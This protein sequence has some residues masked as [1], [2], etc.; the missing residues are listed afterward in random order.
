MTDRNQ[1]ERLLKDAYAARRRG[2]VDAI[3]GCFADQ[4]SFTLAGA[5]EMSPVAVQCTDGKGLRTLLT[6]LVDTFDWIDQKIPS[7]IIE[8]PKAAVH[9]RGRIRSKVSGEEVVTEL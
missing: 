2:D 6:G 9:W 1:V 4:P 8:G 3:C 7:M 5:P